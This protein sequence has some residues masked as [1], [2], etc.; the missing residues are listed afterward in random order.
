MTAE[1]A[2]LKQSLMGLA[3][4]YR[5][6]IFFGLFVN[7]MVLTP[8]WYMLEVYDRVIHSRNTTTLVMLTGMAIFIYLVMEALEWVR[9]KMMQQASH[10][11]EDQLHGRIFD[12]AFRARMKASDFPIQQVF[13]DFR[14]L[15]DALSS[16]AFFGLVDIPYVLIFIIAIFLIHPLLGWMTVAGLALQTLIAV[17]NQIRVHPRMR[18]ANRHAVAAQAYFSSAS[19]RADIVSAM[20]MLPG[21]HDRWQQKQQAFLVHQAKASEIAGKNAAASRLLQVMQASLVLGA[22]CYLEINGEMPYGAAGMIVASILAARALSPF[23]QVVEQW[24]VLSGAH[25]AYV[26]ID[27]LF[28][29]FPQREESMP[30]PPPTGL[31][32]VENLSYAPPEFGKSS[33]REP[34]L[35]NIRFRLNPG[36]VLLVAGPSGS[37]KSTLARLLAGLLPPGNGKVRLDGVDAYQWDKAMLGGHIGYLPQAVELLDGTLAE[38]ISR[39]GPRDDAALQEVIALLNL[40]DFIDS[41]PSGPETQIGH[42][43][44]FLSGG[45]R[46]LV[47]LARAI[48]GNPRIVILDEPNANL[49]E[50][51]EQALHDM[52][53]ALKQR[54]TTFIVISH[55]QGIK[56]VADYM[57]VLMNG[58]VLRYG[59]PDEVLASLHPL[60]DAGKRKTQGQE[61][62]VS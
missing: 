23:M 16:P 2:T 6:I 35:R 55:V 36:E 27:E 61:K 4:Y 21:L 44:T 12:A 17:L 40:Q 15:R 56:S 49:D 18:E 51:G 57:M 20:D 42:D 10:K 37:G 50:E 9:R 14:A 25:S 48:Y 47:G 45:R 28:R 43:G 30:L 54:G 26:R 34:L 32:T 60:A 31:V 1:N 7:L 38:N 53:K 39:F 29:H 52:V 58:Q 46:Q 24:R 62:Q 59:K 19:R 13:A 5:Q 22:A 41:L 11:L 3:A 33:L 8:S